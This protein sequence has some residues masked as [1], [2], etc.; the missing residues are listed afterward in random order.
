MIS[1]AYLSSDFIAGVIFTDYYALTIIDNV[2]GDSTWAVL[3]Y[4][5]RMHKW[6]NSVWGKF[7][8]CQPVLHLKDIKRQ[9]SPA[10]Y[11]SD[12]VSQERLGLH[13]E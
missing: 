6:G 3:S 7:L 5:H 1:Y 10:N 4:R 11:E 8:C 13:Q 2:S 9:L 12:Q